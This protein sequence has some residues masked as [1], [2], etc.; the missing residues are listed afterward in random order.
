MPSSTPVE[1][2]GILYLEVNFGLQI[3]GGTLINQIVGLLKK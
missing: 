2:S 1:Y 3:L